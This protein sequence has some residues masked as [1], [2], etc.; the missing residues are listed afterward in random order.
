MGII[1]SKLQEKSIISFEL[2]EEHSIRIR[3]I[4]D[5]PMKQDEDGR[6][7]KESAIRYDSTKMLLSRW[8]K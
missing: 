3:N 6:K 8:T 2:G 4:L 1:V 5:H 7:K